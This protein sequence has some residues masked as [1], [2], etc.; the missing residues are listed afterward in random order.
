MSKSFVFTPFGTNI[1]RKHG[2]QRVVKILKK[3]LSIPTS[4]AKVGGSEAK[5]GGNGVKIVGYRAKYRG[6]ETK[7]EASEPKLHRSLPQRL[8]SWSR[9]PQS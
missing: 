3:K 9:S 2:R 1:M 6:D 4:G 5:I 7:I 8:Q